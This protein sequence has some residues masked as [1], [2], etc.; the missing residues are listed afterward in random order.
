MRVLLTDAGHLASGEHQSRS[1]ESEVQ[2]NIVK[3]FI[4]SFKLFNIIYYVNI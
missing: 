4:T 1:G 3:S 2:G